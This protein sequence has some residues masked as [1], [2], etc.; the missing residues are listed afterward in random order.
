[1]KIYQIE[2][3]NR[4]NLACS[5]C[6]HPTQRR[7]QGLMSRE[8]FERSVEL[9]LR[10]GQRTAYLHNFGE[11]LLHPEVDGLVRHC[12]SR[13]VAASFFTN[14]VLVTGEVLAALSGAGLRF[15]YVSE[16]TR[17]EGARVRELIDSGGYPIELRETFRPVQTALH[18]WAG[19]VTSQ[20]AGAS[21]HPSSGPGPC[22][23]EREHAAVILWDGRVNV[24]C[25][26]VEGRGV[27]GSVDD[28]IADPERYRFR[29]IDLCA[30]CT[31]MRGDEDL[32]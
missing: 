25:I 31:L 6:P 26:D 13:G 20:A 28:Y 9:L 30:G 12:T 19:Q 10:C 11:P 18:T 17:G 22:L 16:H 8:T 3:S 15:L 5:Y 23:F 27:Q 32:S 21:P 4:C 14:G 24:C 29:G 7:R 2:I 1:M